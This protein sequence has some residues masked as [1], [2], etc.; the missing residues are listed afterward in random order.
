MR[1]K[2]NK[3]KMLN[4]KVKREFQ[5]WLLLRI[6]ATVLVSSVVAGV[7]LYFYARNEMAA[8]FYEAHIKIRRVSDL[9]LPVIIAGSLVSLL[10][11]TLLAIFLPQRIAGP[12]YRIEQGLKAVQDG[13]LDLHLTLRQ[14][15][16]LSELAEAIN[17]TVACL[18]QRIYKGQKQLQENRT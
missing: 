17:K 7:I 8:S 11:G 6:L 10:S 3:R 12:L 16:P 14:D 1:N 9:L 13:D 18:R 5:I 2:R 4:T 15:D